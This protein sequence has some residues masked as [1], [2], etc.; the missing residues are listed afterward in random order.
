MTYYEELTSRIEN[1]EDAAR[2]TTDTA[3]A[4][5]WQAKADALKKKRDKVIIFEAEQAK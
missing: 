4:V 5:I 3:F 2:R 1:L